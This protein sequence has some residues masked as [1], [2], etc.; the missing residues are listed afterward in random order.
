MAIAVAII[1][2]GLSIVRGFQGQS[3]MGRAL[4]GDF[5]Q[6]YVI[7]K[8]L[9]QYEPARMYDLDLEVP[10]QHDTAPGISKDQMLVFASAPYVGLVFR[11]LALLPYRWAYLAWLIFSVALYATALVLLLR[12]VQLSASQMKT[13]FLLAIS[14]MPFV[15]E[16]WIG[17][18]IS[19]L[20]FFSIALFVFLR[21]RNH[22]FLAGLALALA[23]FKPT[24]LAIPMLM[25][26]IGRRWRMLGGA[27]TGAAGLAMVS[28]AMVGPKGCVAWFDT[29]EFYGRLAAGP[30]AALRRT[31]YVDAGSFFHLLLGNSSRL[32]QV[33]GTL[34]AIVALAI[35]ARVWWRS[36]SSWNATSRDLLWASTFAGALVFN[37]Y[38]PIYDTILVG[39]AAA[40]AAG[41]ILRRKDENR[42]AFQAWL[43]LL[44]IVPW[45]TQSF[46]EFLRFQPFTLVLAGFAW[47]T[48]RLAQRDA[49]APQTGPQDI[50]FALSGT[51]SASQPEHSTYYH[52]LGVTSYAV[53]CHTRNSRRCLSVLLRSYSPAWTLIWERDR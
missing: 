41:A 22:R 11:P 3:F 15:M 25:L 4:G 12:S 44:Y 8:I 38:T 39:A 47:W 2:C 51:S 37:V 40:L 1:V 6:F 26:A 43:V 46:A 21:A 16:T 36:S 18:Q 10:L 49:A 42:E 19:V 48:L 24:L 50:E 13:G 5:A 30:A 14:S 33:L 32:A 27:V 53:S 20:A 28:I 7:G 45:V 23:F 9:N 35:L 52:Q 17:G 29:L 31:K 34:A